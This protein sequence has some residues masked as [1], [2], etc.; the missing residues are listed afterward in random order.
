MG[1]LR[2]LWTVYLLSFVPL[3]LFS[4]SQGLAPVGAQN[5]SPYVPIANAGSAIL[6]DGALYLYG[7]VS[8]FAPDPNGLNTGTNQFL[9]LDLTHDFNTTAPP[10]TRL[11]N[12]LTYTMIEAAPSKN[13]KQF[14]LGGNRDN[15]GPLSYI[16]DISSTNWI[17]APNL[18][19][20]S[21]M[22]GYKRWNA[23]MAL[24]PVTGLITIYG[25]FPFMSFSKELS[26]LNT[27]STDPAQM[28]WTY[29]V[30][31]TVIPPLYN[32]MV[33]YLPTLS[34]TIVL[35]GCDTYNGLTGRISSC[36]LL[37]TVYL[38]SSSEPNLIQPR[39]LMM[40]PKPRYQVCRVVLDDGNVFIQGG[41]DLTSFFGDAWIL[42]V[43]NWTWSTITINGP[44]EAM[45]RAG[46]TCQ[47][48]PNGQ[49]I[50]VGGK[51]PRNIPAKQLLFVY[52]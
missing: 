12:Y 52:Q 47:M 3:V 6:S 42:D 2:S 38:F 28:S 7:G 10:W 13:G 4:L 41:R 11:P 49:I 25:G 22:N 18:P 32:P 17:A 16:Y 51:T 26:I 34:K 9:R 35:G 37:T 1:V 31:Q 30:N 43:S 40:G 24:D 45:T 48:G 50:A 21:S 39:T 36:A 19:Y 44:A 33:L 27:T 23:G 29:S 15:N 5:S 8:A 46:H 14:I 20:L